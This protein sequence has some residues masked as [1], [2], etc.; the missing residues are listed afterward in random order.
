MSSL[1]YVK[2]DDCK[3]DRLHDI[4]QHN[5]D[6]LDA[7]RATVKARILLKRY[8]LGGASFAGRKKQ[9]ICALCR[10]EEETTEHFLVVCE[11]LNEKR[12]LY[13]KHYQELAIEAPTLDVAQIVLTP[14]CAV[15]DPGRLH[16]LERASRE[17]IFALHSRRSILLGGDSRYTSTKKP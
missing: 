17:M 9:P 12:K 14:R 10:T 1:K 16:S 3:P 11:A 8:P 6:P 15:K 4:W 13:F 5:N 7:H 2:L